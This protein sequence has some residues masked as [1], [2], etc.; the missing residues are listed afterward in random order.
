MSVLLSKYEACGDTDPTF[1]LA[2]RLRP[3]CVERCDALVAST[4]IS[5]GVQ[6]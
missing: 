2:A 5:A 1:G 6:P 3:L 4:V